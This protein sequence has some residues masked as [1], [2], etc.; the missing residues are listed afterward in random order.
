MDCNVSYSQHHCPH[1]AP[2]RP[3]IVQYVILQHRKKYMYTCIYTHSLTDQV[4]RWIETATVSYIGTCPD[5][6]SPCSGYFCPCIGL[7]GNFDRLRSALFKPGG[8]LETF[9]ASVFS[10]NENGLKCLFL[11]GFRYSQGYPKE[12]GRPNKTQQ[13]LVVPNRRTAQRAPY[14][15]LLQ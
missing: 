9:L 13:R 8:E 10:P 5:A 6:P 1:S 3:C 2:C 11:G 4:D 15:S 14:S 7:V 12:P